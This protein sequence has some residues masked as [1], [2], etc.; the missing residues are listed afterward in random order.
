MSMYK[1]I[2]HGKEHRKPWRGKARSKNI[3]GTC[4]NHGSCEYCKCNRL[5][6]FTRDLETA[7]AKLDEWR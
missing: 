1:A 2:E 4:R 5:H 6:K 7:N 3:D